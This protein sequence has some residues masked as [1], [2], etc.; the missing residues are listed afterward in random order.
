MFTD[1]APAG[2][3]RD[4]PAIALC[5]PTFRRNELLAACLG[6]LRELRIPAGYRLIPIVADNDAA[7]GARA[8]CAQL[9][10]ALPWP[11]EYVIEP[12][13]G[14]AAIRNRL[15]DE[16]VH[17]GADWIALLDDD[18]RP[19]PAWL[20]LHMA[21]LARYGAAVST[22]P[23][24]QPE[25]PGSP[26]RLER[27]GRAT[28]TVPRHVACNNVVFNVKLVADQGLRFDP[29]FDFL[30][31]EDF[32]FFDA[33]ARAGNAHIW[34]AEA[35]VFESVPPER[36]TA[37]Y[38]FLRHFSGAINSVVRY[39][40]EHSALRAW[41]H[42]GIKSLGKLVSA[43]GALLSWP[44]RGRAAC[45]DFIKRIANAAGYLSALLNVRVERYR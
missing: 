43:G 36:A 41:L 14:L 2:K 42:F 3:L 44:V 24:V 45:N 9:G 22:G 12:Q 11:L 34:N 35:V 15:L 7:G 27:S 16:A 30:G 17:H 40:K 5:I 25:T 31:G 6:S 37:G 18:E 29:R 4:Q 20:E 1:P 32:D 26:E 8:L 39:R 33:S 21:A 28:G 10:A 13:R 38:L 23:V 19:D